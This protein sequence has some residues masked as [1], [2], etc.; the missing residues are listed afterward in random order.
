MSIEDFVKYL[1]VFLVL[2]ILWSVQTLV[3]KISKYVEIRTKNQKEMISS[4]V[5]ST[6]NLFSIINEII[7][8]EITEMFLSLDAIKERYKV[9]NLDNDTKAIATVVY[10]AIKKETLLDGELVVEPDY[11]IKYIND[12]VK[13]KIIINVRKHNEMLRGLPVNELPPSI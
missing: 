9:L 1:L 13:T 10:E 11:I 8:A 5:N 3:R 2:L 7:D 4:R 12:Q 6:S